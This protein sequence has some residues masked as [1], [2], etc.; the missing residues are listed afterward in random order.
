MR[1]AFATAAVAALLGCAS[2][3]PRPQP[4]NSSA[5]IDHVIVGVSNLEKAMQ[6]MEDLTGVRPAIGGVHPGQGTR[7]A[8]MSL[9]DGTYLELLAPDPAQMVDNDIVR[10][11][12]ALTEPRPVS[13]AVS[14]G[15]AASLRDSLA[16]AGVA[17][18]SPEAGSRTKPDG[19]RL[20]WVTFEFQG[21]DDPLAP[22]FIVWSDPARHP[23]RT[24]P[25]GCSLAALRIGHPSPVRLRN[26]VRA[27]RLRVD[28]ETAPLP[29]MHLALTC[30]KG[31][32][33]LGQ[34]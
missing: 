18:S 10:E 34:E 9:G 28:V 1:S 19:S 6:Q 15:D 5:R 25:A 29:R 32:I 8:L 21:F 16:A 3:Q 24:S 27:L 20:H 2:A 22:F 33:D 14:A 17:T 12:R 13:W 11:L 7:N 4:A 26:A 23:S 30:P 31:R